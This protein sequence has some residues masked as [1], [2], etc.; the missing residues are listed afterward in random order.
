[1]ISE[2]EKFY[3]ETQSKHFENINSSNI[4][5]FEYLDFVDHL[6]KIPEDLIEYDIEKIET[7][8]I[9]YAAKLVDYKSY[10]APRKIYEFL[11]PY[12]SYS[13][14]IKYQ[15]IKEQMPIHVDYMQIQN[16]RPFIFNYVLI[17][18]G[19]NVN[20]RHWKLP[21]ELPEKSSGDYWCSRPSA[22]TPFWGNKPVDGMKILNENNIPEKTWCRLNVSIPHDISEIKSPRLLLTVFGR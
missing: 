13:I 20:T 11:K 15:I 3:W 2:G 10:N 12:F 18:G 16:Q 14:Q 17:S 19:S 22:R 9:H 7:F 4:N 5:N 21:E 8:K 1:M 6:P